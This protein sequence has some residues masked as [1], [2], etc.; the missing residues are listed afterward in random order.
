MAALQIPLPESSLPGEA[1]MAALEICKMSFKNYILA[2]LCSFHVEALK[3]DGD[4]EI[5]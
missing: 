4:A 2:L 5:S 1:E 3:R